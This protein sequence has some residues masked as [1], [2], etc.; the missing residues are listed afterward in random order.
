MWQFALAAVSCANL[1][2]YNISCGAPPWRWAEGP[3]VGAEETPGEDGSTLAI[4]RGTG[5]YWELTGEK[6]KNLWTWV[7]WT[8]VII[9]VVGWQEPSSYLWWKILHFFAAHTD[10]ERTGQYTWGQSCHQ[11]D[12]ERIKGQQKSCEVQG[13]HNSCTREGWALCNNM[14]W[15]LPG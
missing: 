9:G 11:R 10:L 3:D 2:S 7:M 12:P 8:W 4:F 1:V 14:G 13:Q 6:N 15:G 5:A